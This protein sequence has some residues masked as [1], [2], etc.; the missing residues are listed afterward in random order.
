MAVISEL[1]VNVVAKTGGMERGL[2]NA[3]KGF[4]SFKKTI[5]SGMAALGGAMSIGWVGKLAADMQTTTVRFETMMGS[6]SAAKKLLTD[7]DTF[8]ATTPFQFD[9]LTNGA[10]NLMSFGVAAEDVMNTMQHLGDIAAGT[11]AT[12]D[13]IVNVFGKVQAKG[14]AS[15]EELN[16][17][18]EAGVPILDVL[19]SQFGKTKEEVMKMVSAGEV[20]GKDFERA[21]FSM[22]DK[23]GM[24]F[25]MM[26]KQSKTLSGALSTL[27]DNFAKVGREIGRALLP[28]LQAVV[29]VVLKLVQGWNGLSDKSRKMIITIG[30]MVATFFV[31]LKVMTTWLKMIKMITAAQAVQNVVQAVAQALAGNWKAVAMA[32]VAAASVGVGMF[33]LLNQQDNKLKDIEKKE[34]N[35][36]KAIEKQA[37][38]AVAVTDE[39][40]KQTAELEKQEKAMKSRAA[41][42]AES[43]LTPLEKATKAMAEVN[44]L[45]EK[46]FLDDE[47]AARKRVEIQKGLLEASKTDRQDVE[48]ERAIGAAPFRSAGGFSAMQEARR[49]E[50]EHRAVQ[51]AQLAEQRRQT[52]LLAELNA[53]VAATDLGIVSSV[54][55]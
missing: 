4:A 27:K 15:M 20:S 26:D 53:Q 55:P 39:Q 25:E 11:P 16:R 13:Q 47:S 46:G 10:A 34:S 28:I 36:A 5:A 7:I 2:K 30:A 50:R 37:T 22:S 21:L 24:F 42:I 49:V 1:A 44:Q 12:F 48:R 41:A 32:A 18:M 17:L 6:A 29:D 9:D 33:A 19:A 45:A 23:G 51:E 43:V 54:G 14:K 8:A 3:K 40:K 52:D 35:R 38:A 31:V